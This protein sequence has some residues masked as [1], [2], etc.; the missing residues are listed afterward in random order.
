MEGS[1]PPDRGLGWG[2]VRFG[3]FGC[4]GSPLT[5]CCAGRFLTGHG[6]VPVPGPA[7]AGL[8]PLF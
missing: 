5:T 6:A 1:F 8:G 2:S 3:W 7:G 4:F